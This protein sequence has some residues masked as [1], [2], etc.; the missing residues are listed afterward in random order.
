[1]KKC[2]NPWVYPYT[3]LICKDF[4]PFYTSILS[5]TSTTQSKWT[6]TKQQKEWFN[7]CQTASMRIQ[8]ARYYQWQWGLHNPKRGMIFLCLLFLDVFRSSSHQGY[9]QNNRPWP[10]SQNKVLRTFKNQDQREAALFLKYSYWK[11]CI[12]PIMVIFNSEDD[13]QPSKMKW[14]SLKCS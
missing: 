4:I 5:K 13:D 1:M 11:W 6:R 3:M 12:F 2:V 10:P 8:H 7:M 14:A 9:L